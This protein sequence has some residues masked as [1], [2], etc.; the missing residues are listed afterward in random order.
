MPVDV[1]HHPVAVAARCA[2]GGPAGRARPGRRRRR[3]PRRPPGS[4]ARPAY[5]FASISRCQPASLITYP[6]SRLLLAE[7]TVKRRAWTV[8]AQ[9]TR[10]LPFSG[11]TP[12]PDMGYD[13]RRDRPIR[14]PGGRLREEQDGEVQ[15]GP[16]PDTASRVAHPVDC[17]GGDGGDRRA[18]GRHGGGTAGRGRSTEAEPSAARTDR[19]LEPDRRR[20]GAGRLPRSV[21]TGQ[22]PPV[23][24]RRTAG[25]ADFHR[26]GRHREPGRAAQGPRRPG[27]RGHRDHR[28]CPYGVGPGRQLP[29]RDP[30]PGRRRGQAGLPAG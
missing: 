15:A 12:E 2:C 14:E 17:Q 6:P 22:R 5:T 23:R 1:E 11:S 28:C 8:H 16:A 18:R 4:A 20:A 30:G 9:L 27:R 24:C 29:G 26:V 13:D 25:D 21:A 10:L 7:P 3:A 19:R